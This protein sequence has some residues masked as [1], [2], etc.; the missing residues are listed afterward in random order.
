MAD[1]S[2]R[3]ATCATR[4]RAAPEC[5]ADPAAVARP[6]GTPLPSLRAVWGLSATAPRLRTAA[7]ME[8]EPCSHAAAGRRRRGPSD[9]AAYRVRRAVALPQPYAL[10][11]GPG[12]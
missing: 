6:S 5:A 9:R 1:S 8:G 11:G 12:R 7:G 10:L 2:A 3:A 4:T